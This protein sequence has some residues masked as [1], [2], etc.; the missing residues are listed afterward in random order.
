MSL[1]LF[2]AESAISG[3]F[4]SISPFSKDKKTGN[5]NWGDYNYPPVLNLVHYDPDDVENESLRPIVKTMNH[6]FVITAIVSV[7]NLIDTMIIAP[8]NADARWEWILYSALNL[9]VIPPLSFYVF[10]TG[11][12]A[13]ALSDSSL[14]SRYSVMGTIQAIFFFLFTLTPFGALNG[15]LSF[16]IYHVG[17]VWGIAI[18]VESA[19]WATAFGMTVYTVIYIVRADYQTLPLATR[20]K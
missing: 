2:F 8:L 20:P 4:K 15:L 18:V 5:I 17:V 16:A 13:M 7:L 1:G 19:L 11:Y 9:V 3:A 10:F 14:Q 12:K 6:I